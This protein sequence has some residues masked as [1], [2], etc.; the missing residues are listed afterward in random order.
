MN[1]ILD[2]LFSLSAAGSAVVA[3]MLLL[4]LA[5][6]NIFPAKWRYMIG[7]MATGFYVVP[8]AVVVPWLSFTLPS[9]GES[10]TRMDQGAVSS[11]LKASGMTTISIEFSYLIIAVWAAGA[12]V[13][14]TWQLWCYHRFVKELEAQASPIA[15]DHELLQQLEEIRHNIG[16]KRSVSLKQCSSVKSPLLVGFFKPTIVLP[17]DFSP[18]DVDMDM[19]LHHELVHLKHNDLWVKLFV[20]FANAIH[21]FNPLAYLLRKE[22]HVWSEFAC[23]EEVVKEMS[24]AQRIR[25]GETLLHVIAGRTNAPSQF[26]ATLSGDGKLVKRRLIRMLAMKKLKKKTVA[27]VTTSLIIVGATGTAAA[28]LGSDSTPPVDQSAAE[29]DNATGFSH[30]EQLKIAKED[31]YFYE[32]G[33]FH[34]GNGNIGV[35]PIKELPPTDQARVI[36][37]DSVP[38]TDQ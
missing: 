10:M 19:I 8:I 27:L 37:E 33:Y 3:C 25:Y 29:P 4:K 12:V 14:L 21:W 15:V 28:A 6:Q 31:G 5:S 17:S 23:D 34:D 22:I 13:F 35:F 24:H 36:N 26:C 9:T 7:K 11:S 32:D 18:M 38:P 30:E 16:V 1:T 2:T 20:L